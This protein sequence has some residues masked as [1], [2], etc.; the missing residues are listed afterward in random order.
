MLVVST[1]TNFIA[2]MFGQ[3]GVFYFLFFKVSYILCI[4]FY[5]LS[6]VTLK[7]A[8]FV[9]NIMTPY[10]F[11]VFLILLFNDCLSIFNLI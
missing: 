9:K 7:S 3:W 4:F 10:L 1:S 11:N 6:I 2:A 5:D 8:D